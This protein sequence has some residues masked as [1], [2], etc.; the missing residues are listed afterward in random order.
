MASLTVGPVGTLTET[1]LRSWCNPSRRDGNK[2]HHTCRVMALDIPQCTCL[3]SQR[4]MAED[5]GVPDGSHH[6]FRKS[7]HY[8]PGYGPEHAWPQSLVHFTPNLT[9]KWKRGKPGSTFLSQQS[10]SCCGRQWRVSANTANYTYVNVN[11]TI[12]WY[13]WRSLHWLWVSSIPVQR[14]AEL[15]SI[16]TNVA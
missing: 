8:L 13:V 15:Q 7:S 6:W 3:F 11:K 14:E 5:I 10:M 4:R 12:T 1:R 9:L 2:G 16:D